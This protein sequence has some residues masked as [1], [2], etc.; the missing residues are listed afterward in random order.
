MIYYIFAF[1]LV[2][3]IAMCA[4][5]IGKVDRLEMTL[6]GQNAGVAKNIVEIKSDIDGLRNKMAKYELLE[7]SGDPEM[8]RRIAER[9]EKKW[10]D[11]LQ[12]LLDFNPLTGK[13][14]EE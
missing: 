12:A 4:W 11:G 7:E 5:L 13:G 14:D 2:A 3:C 10:D 9:I 1:A 8:E 6:A